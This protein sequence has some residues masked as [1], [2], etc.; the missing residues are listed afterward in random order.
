[1]CNKH[2]ITRGPEQWLDSRMSGTVSPKKESD[3]FN[4]TIESG[5]N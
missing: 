2:G 3:G 1:M 4:S 5:D